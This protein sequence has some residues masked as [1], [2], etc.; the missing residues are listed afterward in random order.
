[1][2]ASP[3]NYRI[4]AAVCCSPELLEAQLAV[5]PPLSMYT[6]AGNLGVCQSMLEHFL[7]DRPWPPV[8]YPSIDK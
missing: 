4:A 7:Q 2:Q 8:V 6:I 3:R 5:V 1:M